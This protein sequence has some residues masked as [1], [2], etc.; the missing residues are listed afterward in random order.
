MSPV[1]SATA[2]AA[3]CA[4]TPGGSS[5]GAR[6]WSTRRSS[7]S[8]ATTPSGTPGSRSAWGLERIAMLRHEFPDLRELWRNDLRFARQFWICASRSRGCASMSRRPRPQSDR[9][10]ALDS[11]LEVERVIDVGVVDERR[12]PRTL[13]RRA[14]AGDR[15]APQRRSAPALPGRRGQPGAAADRVPRLE[16]RRGRNRRGRAAGRTLPGFP[17]PLKERKLRGETLAG[18]DPR[19]GRDRARRGPLRDHAAAGGPRTGDSPRRRVA[20]RRPGAG[21]DANEAGPTSCRWSAWRERSPRCSTASCA[22][23]IR[24]T[25]RSRNRACRRARRGLRR[26]SALHG[27]APSATSRS[28]VAAVAAQPAPPRGHTLDLQRGRHHE[29]RDA[30]VG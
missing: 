8:S 23:P 13:R 21:R 24:R 2:P 3:A 28:A 4:G 14:G 18:N 19:R 12:Q 27:L 26:L 25:R 11:A 29:L 22:R 16:L 20:D 1:T 15:T 6:G 5:S 9:A 17:G 10:A 30:R 7:S